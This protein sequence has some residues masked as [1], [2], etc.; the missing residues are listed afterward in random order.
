[1]AVSFN[2]ISPN[3]NRAFSLT[4]HKISAQRNCDI[5]EPVNCKQF[6]LFN[7][8]VGACNKF[9]EDYSPT[10]TWNEDRIATQEKVA[11][12]C[13]IWVKAGHQPMSASCPLSTQQRRKSGHSGTSAPCHKQPI[14]MAI[15][16]QS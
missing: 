4:T 2:M 10:R 7:H 5:L 16:A 3:K 8:P 6:R 15:R 13:R 11:R 9:A 14:P 12:P 1:M